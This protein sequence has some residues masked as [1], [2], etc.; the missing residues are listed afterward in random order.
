VVVIGAG[1]LRLVEYCGGGGGGVGGG[2][3]GER[4]YVVA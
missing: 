3:R 2:C 1:C 4:S